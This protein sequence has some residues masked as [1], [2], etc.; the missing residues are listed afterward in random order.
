MD[1]FVT[2]E[3]IE[4]SVLTI[5]K[6]LQT[7]IFDYGEEDFKRLSDDPSVLE[8]IR[9]PLIK[10]AV[11]EILINLRH[12]L[13]AC[14]E[15]GDKRVKFDDDIIKMKYKVKYTN[16]NTKEEE[17]KDITDA[18]KY[19]R[20]AVCHIEDDE[21]RLVESMF[22]DSGFLYNNGDVGFNMGRQTLYIKKHIVRAL[23]EAK[24]IL[25]KYL[26]GYNERKAQDD[27]TN[28]LMSHVKNIIDKK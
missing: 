8:K 15:L 16:G 26:I 20:D 10:S 23:E 3:K 13:W 5:E 17:I 11:V 21:K 18:V 9:N 1:D 12:L 27:F 7:G 28:K 24:I 2:K 19:M 4:N 22:I 25:S 6:I 14:E